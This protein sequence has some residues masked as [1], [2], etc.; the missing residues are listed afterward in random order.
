VLSITVTAVT[1]LI[2]KVYKSTK[3]CIK[4]ACISVIYNKYGSTGKISSDVL[5][6]KADKIK[7]IVIMFC[8]HYFAYNFDEVFS[9]AVYTKPS[10]EDMASKL[11]KLTSPNHTNKKDDPD[12]GSKADRLPD[13][14]NDR[15]E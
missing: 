10:Y 2:I 14:K 8:K 3:A 1:T 15:R 6:D 7:E 12:H 9:W 13:D 11:N 4:I 5:E